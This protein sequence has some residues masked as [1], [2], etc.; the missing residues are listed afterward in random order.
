MPKPRKP[1]HKKVKAKVHIFCE[2]AK[3]EP[4]YIR[5]YINAFHPTCARL[6]S[7]EKPIQ[8]KDTVKNTPKQL[9]DEAVAFAMALEFEGDAVWVMYDREAVAKYSDADHQQA[10]SKANKKGVKVALSNV[11]FEFWL[12]LHLN[13]SSL[14][15]GKC[16]D[17]INSR[18]FKKAF[19]EIG[20]AQYEKGKYALVQA[21]MTLERINHAKTD[22]KRLNQQ[23]INSANEADVDLPYRLNPYTNVYEVLEAIDGVASSL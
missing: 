12:L 22:A 7:A 16:D 3:T 17:V 8:I 11:C 5:A 2:G 1:A 19:N 6:K 9:V 13:S 15:A 20:F 21:L 18:I 23:T 4:N 14:S 10:W